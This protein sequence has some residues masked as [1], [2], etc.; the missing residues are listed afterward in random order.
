MAIY[1]LTDP[2]V[3]LPPQLVLDSS[4]LLA[5]R[6]GD[7]N[8]HALAVQ[9]FV[10]RLREQIAAYQMVV[11]LLLP[12]LQECYHIILANSLRRTWAAMDPAVRPANWLAMYKRQPELLKVGFPDLTE[13][14]E[15]VAT[16]PLTPVQPEDLTTS[17]G[18]E[19]LEERLLYFMT[20]YHLLS[21]DALILAEAERLGVSAVATLD[22]DWQRVAVFDVYTCPNE[23]Q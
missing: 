3:P 13:F 15:I 11:W 8:P 2:S 19:P 1:D 21:Q 14:G 4:L 7:D 18:A 6:P 22:Q 5:L 23:S 20:T 17:V 9:G 12:V 16:I 10:R